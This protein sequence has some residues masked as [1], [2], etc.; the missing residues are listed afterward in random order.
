MKILYITQCSVY[1]NVTHAGGMTVNYYM[2]KLNVNNDLCMVSFC[3]P[4]EEYLIT[5]NSNADKV[6][7]IVRDGNSLMER[8]GKICSIPS[9]INV[10]DKRCGFSKYASH[11]LKNKLKFVSK[12]FMPDLII[13][14]WTGIILHIDMIKKIFPAIPVIASEHD[15]SFLGAFRRADI[16]KKGIIKCI[17][18]IRA[19]WLRKRELE[20]LLKADLVVPHN[21]K[22]RNLLLS[23]GIDVKKIHTIVPYYHEFT[24]QECIRNNDIIFF[25]YMARSENVNAIKWFIDKVMPLIDDLNVRFIIIGGGSQDLKYIEND[26]VR[27]IGYVE[28]PSQW[29]AK[30]MC[31]VAPLQLGAGIKVKVIEALYSGITVLTNNIGIEGIQAVNRKDYYHCESPQ[32]YAEIIR[33]IYSGKINNLS[34]KCAIENQFSLERSYVEYYRKMYMLTKNKKDTVM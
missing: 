10:F 24:A 23:N 5:T 3:S 32:D 17:K 1:E 12:I 26:K 4:D 27:I 31:F 30:S 21:E 28:D 34:G 18:M 11:L 16:E 15:V 7:P 25:G 6:F 13:L 33:G 19:K 29:F 20:C 9:K 8:L 22:D 14:E 2:K